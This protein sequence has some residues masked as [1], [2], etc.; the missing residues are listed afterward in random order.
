MSLPDRVRFIQR[1]AEDLGAAG[2]L[3]SLVK[4]IEADVREG[5]GADAVMLGL[6]DP[7]CSSLVPV[8]AEGLQPKTLEMLR[9]PTPLEENAPATAA[10]LGGRPVLWSSLAERDKQFPAYASFPSAMQS[11]AILPLMV[12]RTAI[13]V[14]TIG[15]PRKHRFSDVDSALLQVIGH[16][17]AIAVDRARIEQ[18]RRA[19]RD[20]LELLSEGTR[21]M[22]SAI[23]PME[24][25][26]RLVHL[27]VPRL[28]PWC[29]VYVVE[30]G[31]LRRLAI[32]I[33]GH[34]QLAADLRGQVA[35]P[36]DSATPLASAFRSGEAQIVPVEE[37]GVRAMYEERHAKEIMEA[38]ATWSA[39]VVPVKATGRAIGAMSLVSAAWNGEP[40]DE[41]R[42][43]AEGLAA[44]AGIA[45]TNARRYE[46]ERRT[47]AMLMEAFLPARLAEVPGYDVAARYLPAGANVAGDWFDLVRLPS[48]QFLVGIGDAGGHGTQAAALMGQ[49]RNAARGLA[50]AG[51]GP[52]SLLD[53][54]RLLTAEEGEDNFAT[55][56]YGL[57]DPSR[58]HLWWASAGHLPPLVYGEG[59]ARFLEE[60]RAPPLPWPASATS[61]HLWPW[62][63]RGMVL[64]TDGVV[65]RRSES[66]EE[67]MERLRSFVASQ[68]PLDAAALT[69]RIVLDLC[70]DP[71]DDCC[72][73][74]V[75]RR[76]T[77][78]DSGP[79][80]S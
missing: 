58:H 31:M 42:F 78:P 22:V 56:V 76:G 15:W 63:T 17:C 19:E 29:A 8:L 38:G 23:E 59:E 80:A 40:S 62:A 6:V 65:E 4:V 64:V 45:L 77:P 28:A 41:V 79:P 10:L 55:A 72:V 33:E 16:Q 60:R 20:T 25:V 3:A 52:G 44:R 2:D 48:G 66:I 11:W 7:E 35:V 75:Q 12:H 54:L 37:S 61:Q 49:L 70:R 14:L 9:Q 39:L 53:A 5:L 21:L 50:I 18:V 68:P 57:L 67:G 71:Q 1:F 32:E 24:V 26:N 47:A 46:R 73:V 27:A 36:V 30:G 51:H 34:H 69:D 13:G 74:V 43:A